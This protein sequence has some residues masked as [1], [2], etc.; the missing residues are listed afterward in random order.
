MKMNN[1]RGMAAIYYFMIAILFFV[2][3]L[4]LAPTLINTSDEA[5]TNLDCTNSSISNQDKSVC[6][7]IDS[8]SPLYIG[9]I[10]GLGGIIIVRLIS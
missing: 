10:F 2:I 3:G 9:I 7:Q 5:Q 6:Y 8:M 4:A 1:K